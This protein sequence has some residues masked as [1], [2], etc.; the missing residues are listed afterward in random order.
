MDRKTF[1]KKTIGALVIAIPAYSILS[2][3]GSDDSEPSSPPQGNSADCASNGTSSSIGTNHGHTLTVSAADVAAGTE[4]T[5]NIQGTS[6]HAHSVTVTA[7][8]FTSLQSNQQ[9]SSTSSNDSGHTHSV[10]ISCA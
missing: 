6:D 8:Q 5:Y 3:S 7:A 2:C 1:I 10:T 9:I 4:K